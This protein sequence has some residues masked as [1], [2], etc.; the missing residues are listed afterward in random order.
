VKFMRFLV[1]VGFLAICASAARADGVDPKV[2]TSGCGTSCDAVVLTPGNTTVTVSETFSCDSS[3]N[4]TATDDVYNATGANINS[5]TMVFDT[6][7][8][9]LNYSCS[10]MEEQLFTCSPVVGTTNAFTFTGA[11]VCSGNSDD[12]KIVEG[13][14][15]F[16]PDNDADDACGVVIGLTATTSEGISNNETVSSTFATTPEPSSALLLL[17][18]LMVG[19]VVLKFRGSV[20]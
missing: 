16:T 6:L 8:G 3:G 11:S 19:I 13:V 10:T 20:A 14:A 18:G 1:V 9:T 12:Y 7:D 4:C 17:F 5:F 15:V 2:F